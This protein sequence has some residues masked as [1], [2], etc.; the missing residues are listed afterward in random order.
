M[1]DEG[2]GFPPLLAH[3]LSLLVLGR[4]MARTRPYS[5]RAAKVNSMHTKENHSEGGGEEGMCVTHGL[6][7]FYYRF[8]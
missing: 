3:S 5:T 4:R 6:V 1:T 7:W 2:L 8:M